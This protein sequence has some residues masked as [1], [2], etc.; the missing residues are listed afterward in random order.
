MDT[1]FLGQFHGRV[2]A[3]GSFH[4]PPSLCAHLAA[5]MVVTRGLDRCLMLF[6]RQMWQELANRLSGLP[7]TWPAARAL[8]RL[9]FAGALH[10]LADGECHITLSEELCTYAQIEGELVLVGLGAYL[11]MWSPTSWGETLVRVEAEAS[12]LAEELTI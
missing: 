10:C 11:E 4:L 2:D 7:F 8:R 9:L 1:M 12:S 5:G 6:P 3:Q